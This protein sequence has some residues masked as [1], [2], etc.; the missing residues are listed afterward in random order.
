[1]KFGLAVFLN[2]PRIHCPSIS[3]DNR[4]YTVVPTI[5]FES[6]KGPSVE[7]YLGLTNP[8]I[9]PCKLWIFVVDFLCCAVV[10]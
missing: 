7:K 2:Y 9:R 6:Q 3:P 8:L 5:F 1:M 10:C 4:E